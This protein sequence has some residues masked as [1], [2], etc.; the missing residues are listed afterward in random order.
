MVEASE[1]GLPAG[2]KARCARGPSPRTAV[3]V[4]RAYVCLATPCRRLG[5]SRF[6]RKLNNNLTISKLHPPC[7]F[8]WRLTDNAHVS[9]I[10]TLHAVLF[11]LEY[12][13]LQR[14]C[15]VVQAP[16]KMIEM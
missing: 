1:T 14:L 2:R 3:L 13:G 4:H 15:Q 7:S 12:Q 8:F 10:F 5:S 11:G 16:R 9:P 6:C